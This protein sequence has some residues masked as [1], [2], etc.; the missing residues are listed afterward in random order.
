MIRN[1]YDREIINGFRRD[2]KQS[3]RTLYLMYYR[4]LCYFAERLV[5]DKTEAEDIAHEAFL[6]LLDKQ[7]DFDH[8][9]D[10]KSFLFTVARNICADHWRNKKRRES[11]I[12]ELKYLDSTDDVFAEIETVRAKALQLIYE[13]VENLPGQCKKVFKSVFIE[14]KTTSD[15]AAEMGIMPQ[16]VLNQKAKAL[17]ILRLAL[18]QKNHSLAAASLI[19]LSF[20]SRH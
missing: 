6:R 20:F 15:I 17:H 7:R 19:I 10:I 5:D 13:E 16:T 4:S 3:I 11:G 18:A 8:I 2:E 14:G 12:Q 9:S 1:L